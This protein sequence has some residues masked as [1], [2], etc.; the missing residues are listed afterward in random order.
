MQQLALEI[1][2]VR[3]G[4]TIANMTGPNGQPV[5]TEVL[6]QKAVPIPNLNE[7]YFVDS[8]DEMTRAVAVVRAA[9]N[10]ALAQTDSP[11]ATKQPASH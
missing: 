2:R 8:L 7:G 3:V 10:V 6:L 9:T 11:S 5:K 1:D 4:S